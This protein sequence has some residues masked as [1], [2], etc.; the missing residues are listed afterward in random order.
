M[1][2]NRVDVA[3]K[4]LKAN[5]KSS[6]IDFYK[7][8]EILAKKDKRFVKEPLYMSRLYTDILV[9]GRFIVLTEII[10]KKEVHL[11]DIRERYTYAEIKESLSNFGDLI[12]DDDE[13]I[14]EEEKEVVAP[15]GSVKSDLSKE[16]VELAMDL[17][18]TDED[19]DDAPVKD[20]D[21]VEDD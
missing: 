4:Y 5:E 9:D 14:R 7:L 17:A 1:K 2:D 10:N 15:T 13:L 6:P 20:I 21:D 8:Y 19:I 18:K 12:I 16:A 3:F 11:C